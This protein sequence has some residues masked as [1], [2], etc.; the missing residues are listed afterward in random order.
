M[1]LERPDQ[2][3]AELSD[4]ARR[5]GWV[6]LPGLDKALT[7]MF[8]IGIAEIRGRAREA[9]RDRGSPLAPRIF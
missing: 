5:R 4:I 7:D 3:G 2:L 9:R 1:D 6:D 8:G